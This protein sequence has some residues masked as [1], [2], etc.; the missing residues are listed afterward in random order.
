MF[1]FKAKRTANTVENIMNEAE[2][3]KE[4]LKISYICERFDPQLVPLSTLEYYG[5]F[6]LRHCRLHS[7]TKQLK[8]GEAR[9]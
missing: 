5:I 6:R 8:N 7:K 3:F 9:Y 2:I 4:N 1:D